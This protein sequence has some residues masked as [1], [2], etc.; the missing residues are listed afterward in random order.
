MNNMNEVIIA[1]TSIK[2]TNQ[3]LIDTAGAEALSAYN[4][5]FG[6]Q[7]PNIKEGAR[8][9]VVYSNFDMNFKNDYLNSEYRM[10]F[11]FEVSSID[12]TKNEIEFFTTKQGKYEIYE[13]EQG[14]LSTVVFAKWQEIWNDK[15]L[16]ERRNFV[17]DFEVY[18]NQINPENG[19]VKI[20]IG[21]K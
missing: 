8:F 21:V 5:V 7:I 15:G 17:S 18:E 14:N 16:A 11:G 13:T 6:M 4:K 12:T 10:H 1:G 19:K 3:K 9:Y 2:T 20:Y